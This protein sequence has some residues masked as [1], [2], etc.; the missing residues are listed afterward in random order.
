MAPSR[1]QV[2]GLCRFSYVS[3]PGGFADH[4][5][6]L[7]DI[8]A[9]RHDPV[10]LAQRL[11]WLEHVV[12]PSFRVQTDPDFRLVVLIGERLPAAARARLE[13][14]TADIPQVAVVALEEGLRHREACRQAL[15]LHRDAGADVIAEFVADDDDAVAVDF[16][17]KVRAAFPPLRIFFRPRGRLAV[18][19]CRG[20]MLCAGADGLR[21]KPVLAPFWA[22]ALVTYRRPGD[23][24]G[25]LE[26]NHR[27]LWRQMPAMSFQTPLMFVRG[28]H[29][30]NASQLLSRWDRIESF[31]MTGDEIAAALASRFRIDTARMQAALGAIPVLQGPGA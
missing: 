6:S 28:A 20:L 9:Y 21:V 24:Q 17:E 8:R 30:D 3:E 4:G 10:R 29:A 1:I 25:V 27:K 15:D 5:R 11:T 23:D 22:P 16:V 26:T 2:L 14:L 18:D 31:P 7:D 19:F 13:A 12:L